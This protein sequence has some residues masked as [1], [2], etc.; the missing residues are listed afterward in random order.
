V[1]RLTVFSL[2]LLVACVACPAAFAAGQPQKDILMLHSFGRDFKP[3]SEYAKGVRT[4]LNRQSPWPVN[5]IE[6]SLLS[7]LH[8]DEN[9]EGSFVSY[10]R[11]LF[12]KDPPDII[13]SMGAPAAG[14]VQRHRQQLLATTPMVFTAVEQRR[15]Q[16]SDLT[17]NDAVVAVAHDF[18]AIVDNI[19]RILPETKTIAVVVGASPNE[20]FW[21]QEMR[22]EF[23]PF[24]NRVSFEWYNDR[25]FAE[26]LQQAPALPPHTAIYWHSLNIDAAAVVHA[27]ETSL[28]KLYAVANAPIFTFDGSFFGQEIVGGPM[29]SVLNLSRETAAVVV[30]I[31]GGEKAGEIA[32][33]ASGFAS[34]IYDW[35]QLQRWGISESLLPAG[36]EVRFR[37]PSAWQ[38]YRIQILIVAA[39]ILLQAGSITWLVYEQRRG[40]AAELVTR[41]AMFELTQ[42]NRIAGAGELSAS[43]AHEVNQPLAAIALNAGAAL[44]WLK[45]KTPNLEE[46]RDAL[47]RVV[48]DSHRAGHIITSLRALFRKDTEQ[49]GSVE[50]NKV[51]LTVLEL[52]RIELEKYDIAVH[53]QFDD[54]LPP[55]TGSEVQLQQVVLN[56]VMNAK[57]AVQ[58]A[59]L[60]RE[61]RV[62]S[63]RTADGGVQVS[64]EDS[65]AGISPSD[66]PRIFQPMFTTKPN[67]MGMG[68]AICRSIVEAHDGRIWAEARAGAGSAFRFSLPADGT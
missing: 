57:E 40:L 52:V 5:I 19:L 16:R 11:A 65:G 23:A 10:L 44:N 14:F 59:P 36:S 9:P 62:E 4:E 26:I 39:V 34:P 55:M 3:W 15:V 48:S 20:R 13:L 56:L 6:H 1:R 38:I 27:S 54:G 7:A 28:S 53:T 18:P 47:I 33:P 50:I 32:I 29:H 68:L 43:I 63:E 31:L 41:E 17:E 64:V 21:L 45:A 12:S 25:S 8:G 60:P 42:M 51:I 2:V 49:K 30:R 66:L 24:A 35:R 22:R 61:L 37:E 67:G 58:S 46:A